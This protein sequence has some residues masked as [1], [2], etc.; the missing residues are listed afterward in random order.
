MP[1]GMKSNMPGLGQVLK[2]ADILAVLSFI[3]S[4]WAP[5]IQMRQKEITRRALAQQK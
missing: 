5:E 4:R 1:Q 2:D 3:K